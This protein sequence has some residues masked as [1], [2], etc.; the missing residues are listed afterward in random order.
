MIKVALLTI[1]SELLDGRTLDTNVNFLAKELSRNSFSVVNIMTC[2]DNIS[3]IIDAL[4][5]VFQSGC[6]LVITSG[7]LGPTSDDLTREAVADFFRTGV[8]IDQTELTKLKKR[9]LDRGKEFPESNV[10]QATFP[11]GSQIIRNNFGTAPSFL[12]K[13]GTRHLISLPGVPSE[14]KGIFHE[15][16]LPL[17]TQ[18]FSPPRTEQERF[19]FFN[20]PESALNDQIST[21]NLPDEIEV[22]YETTFPENKVILKSTNLKALLSATEQILKLPAAEFLVA[23]DQIGLPDVVHQGLIKSKLKLAIAE[24]CTGGLIG[25]TLTDLSGSS[26]YFLGSLVT[27]HDSAK[28]KVLGVKK[29]TLEK[30]GAVSAECAL[31]MALG[32]KERLSAD[33]AISVTGISGPTGGTDQKPVGTVFLGYA[34]N[35]QSFTKEIFY[36]GTREQV[37]RFATYS[38]LNLLVKFTNS[39]QVSKRLV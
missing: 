38:A 8:A 30:F 33:V 37:R 5:F 25:K 24:S 39:K 22:I 15:E 34:D 29:T 20:I 32:V 19:V 26:S 1:G 14:L 23:R 18:L 10:K 35:Q 2:A 3:N 11:I 17:I 21:L 28:E 6:A 36:S 13:D 4:E 7:G 27:Y 9:Y 16:V 31:E 12:V